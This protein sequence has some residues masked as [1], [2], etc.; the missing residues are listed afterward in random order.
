MQLSI[1]NEVKASPPLISCAFAGMTDLLHALALG[2]PLVLASP[3]TTLSAAQRRSS[4]YSHVGGEALLGPH[5][6]GHS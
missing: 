1:V 2:L 6:G 4:R 5:V 3:L